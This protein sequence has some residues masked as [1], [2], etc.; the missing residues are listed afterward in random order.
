MYNSLAD[1]GGRRRRPP[2]P[3]PPPQQDQFPSF[4]HTFLLK[5]VPI[6]GWHPPNGSVPPQWKI[7]DLPLLNWLNIQYI[8]VTDSVD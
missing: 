8:I 2:P 6:G 5:S 4:S 1:P 7:L 3:P